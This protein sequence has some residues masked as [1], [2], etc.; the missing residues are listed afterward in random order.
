MRISTSTL[1][2]V[3]VTALNQQQS[4]ML[5]TQQQV[6]S[7]RRILT[8]AD[9]P[10]AAARALEVTQADATNSQYLKNISTTNDSVT[11]AEGTLQGVT[12]LLQGVQT[13]A[14]SAGNPAMSNADRKSI[15]T[16]L[17]NNLDQL[18]SMANARDAVGNYL[19]SGFKGNTQ[20][21]DNT[22]TGVQYKGDDGQ[23][24]AQVNSTR[25][26]AASDSGADIFMRIKNGNGT[27]STQPDPTSHAGAGNS[28]SGVIS[29]GA[30]ASPPPTAAQL[31]NRYSI[32]FTSTTSYD[33]MDTTA[34]LPGVAVS[35]GNPYTSG[36]TISFNGIQFAIQ[37]APATGDQFT[38]TPSAN[39]S[40]F[41]TISNLITTLN[42][43]SV[44]GSVASQALLTAGINSAL[45]NLSN[46]TDSV[47]RTR[48]S[49]GTRLNELTSL[50]STGSD[51]G[52][53]Y[54]Q[55]LSQLQDVDYNQAITD[56]TRQQ[57]MLTAAQ[58]SFLQVQNLSMFNY[59]P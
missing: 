55:T 30:L 56:L 24:L 58:K 33:V 54:K 45:N 23:R 21:F 18:I 38:I 41:T 13:M 52:N 31:G 14:V 7:G 36:Q 43:P 29:I 4:T 19:F 48:A 2:D 6:S 32:N 47:L 59:M 37:G 27:F 46:A 50:Q 17:Q 44:P 12:T 39:E 22:P 35:A 57:T 16:S 9:D 1:F 15:A 10:A 5:H 3:N 53:Q 11:A 25:Q 34:G 42:T 40:V 28:G 51:L 8:P 26:L 20:P 49:M